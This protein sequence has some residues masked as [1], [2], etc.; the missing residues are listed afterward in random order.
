MHLPEIFPV[1]KDKLKALLDYAKGNGI[2]HG[3]F[4]IC[5]GLLTIIFGDELWNGPVYQN[6]N[7][8][9]WAPQSWGLVA[10]LCGVIILYGAYRDRERLVRWGC[11]FMAV[12]CFVFASLFLKDFIEYKAALSLP[13]VISYYHAAFL[14]INRSVLSKRVT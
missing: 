6:A 14:M 9:P 13:G 10:L 8:L 1:N 4:A 2:V 7:K 3:L 11:F 12:W 5:Y